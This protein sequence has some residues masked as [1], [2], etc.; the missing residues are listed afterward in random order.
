MEIKFTESERLYSEAREIIPGGVND[1]RRPYKFYPGYY[2]IF[3]ERG[4]GSH[5]WDVDGNEYIDLSC[6]FGP[7]LVGHCNPT[8]DNAVKKRLETGFCF[9]MTHP[10]QNELAKKLI[11]IIPCAEMAK[12]MM[13]GSDGT[14]KL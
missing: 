14:G 1:A 12:F 11:E 2:P 3:S 5:I 6:S 13:S 4:K 9:M 7:N 8:V 10:I